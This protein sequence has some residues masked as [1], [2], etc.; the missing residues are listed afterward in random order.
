M[1]GYENCSCVRIIKKR[2]NNN[3]V[4]LS[5]TEVSGGITVAYCFSITTIITGI[6][7]NNNFKTAS[8]C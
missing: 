2:R 8:F 6:V 1:N 3:Q 5:R 7:K 4:I